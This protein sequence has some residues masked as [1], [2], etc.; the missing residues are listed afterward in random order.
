MQ[1]P[2][3]YLWPPKIKT[4]SESSRREST[5][6]LQQ[7]KVASKSPWANL[8]MP[9]ANW[10]MKALLALTV[11]QQYSWMLSAWLS[12]ENF[13]KSSMHHFYMLITQKF[14]ES[15]PSHW[16]WK[17]ANRSVGFWKGGSCEDKILQI[18]QEIEDCLQR[19]FNFSISSAA[20]DSFNKVFHRVQY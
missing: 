17:L 1:E 12:F 10:S 3:I 18:V 20:G 14:D 19:K 8:R 5:L 2:V 4:S 13:S 16:F 15:L 9:T 11:F 7:M 6:L